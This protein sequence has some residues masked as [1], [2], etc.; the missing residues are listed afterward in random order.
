MTFEMG[1]EGNV[2]LFG[3]PAVAD[4]R[5]VFFTTTD[6]I[7]LG[8]KDAPRQP[9]AVPPLPAVVSDNNRPLVT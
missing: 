8:S 1:R 4:G 9:V 2:E 3:S 6:M 5:V 7:C